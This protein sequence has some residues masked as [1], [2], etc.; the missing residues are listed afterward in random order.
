MAKSKKLVTSLAALAVTAAA[1]SPAITAD[2]A[3]VNP[4]VLK[5]Q[6]FRGGEIVLPSTYGS[7]RIVWD[8]STINWNQINK[9]QTVYGV[10]G[11]QKRPIQMQVNLLNYPIFAEKA[12]PQ[13]IKL[14]EK[15]VL[16]E[17]LDIKFVDKFYPNKINW[18]EAPVADKEGTFFV[19]GSYTKDGRTVVT[20][21]LY[22]VEADAEAAV[23]ISD[24]Q[25]EVK[26][27]KLSVTAKV[28]NLQDGETVEL[29]ILPGKDADEAIE[30]EADVKDGLVTVSADELPV[31]E[32]SFYLRSGDVETKSFD[33]AVL[34]TFS[35]V[36]S[37][38]KEDT[39][40]VTAAVANL[41]KD[42]EVE[43]VIFPG[44]DE[45]EELA[46]DAEVKDGLLTVEAKDI[47]N[48]EH[49]FILRSGDEESKAFD[50]E[51][52]MPTVEEVKA[53]NAKTLSVNL[54]QELTSLD[55]L[56]FSVKRGV[57]SVVLTSK[58]SEDKKSV[59]LSSS[60][61]LVAGEYEVTVT[62]GKF[63]AGTNSAKAIV[64]SQKIG[65]IE[66]TGDVLAKT[67]TGTATVGFKAYDQYGTDITG[68]A[69]SLI[70]NIN[71]AANVAV[72][73]LN[74][75]NGVLTIDLAGASD[76]AA[77]QTILITAVDSVTGTSKAST[78][79]VGA[80]SSVKTLQ[81]GEVVLP[82]DTTRIYTG[83][84]SAATIPVMAKDQY[85]N[86][87]DK[88][89]KLSG[90][91]VLSSDA[92]VIPTFADVDGKPVVNLNTTSLTI[93]KS[94][95][96]TLVVNATGETVTKTVEIVK[97]AQAD[98]VTLGALEA[99]VVADGDVANKFVLPITVVNQFGETM[100]AKQI[101]SAGLVI[102]GT[103]SFAGSALAIDT[104]STS[105]NYGKIVNTSAIGAAGVGTIVVTSPT[106]KTASAN[107]EV[108]AARKV[109]EVVAPK[110]VKTNL[111]SGATTA[112][113]YQFKDQY[114]DLVTASDNADLTWK[115]SVKD[116]TG[117][118]GVITANRT[119]GSD[120]SA[121]NPVTVSATDGKAGTAKVTVELLNASNEVVSQYE[122]T[123]TVVANNAEGLTYSVNDVPTLFASD[124]SDTPINGSSAYAAALSFTA[125]DANG[126]EYA[127]PASQILSVDSVKGYF[128]DATLGNVVIDAQDNKIVIGAV[129]ADDIDF[130][131]ATTVTD[132]IKV[133]INT[134]SGV[135][136]ISK[137][138]TISKVVPK[139]VE[140]SILDNAPTIA[141]P[142]ELPTGT[143]DVT[144]LTFDN[145][146]AAI[147]GTEMVN[148]PDAS[149]VFVVTK[150]QYGVYTSV[151]KDFILNSVNLLTFGDG[152]DKFSTTN[153]GVFTLT[154][155][156]A[157][158]Q[159]SAG[160]A[161]TLS[162]VE[163]GLTD[164]L[165]VKINAEVPP[166][167]TTAAA[168]SIAA[169]GSDD[170]EF[171]EVLSAS[172]KTAVE[173]AI[174][175]A[176]SGVTADKLTFSWAA[177]TLTVGNTGAVAATFTADVTVAKVTDLFGNEAASPVEVIT[178]P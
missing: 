21:A 11:S 145:R 80:V 57:T 86:D 118:A 140:M 62:G 59:E 61:N 48:G 1:V 67:G 175:A 106:G 18:E 102:T 173:N 30:I 28:E 113:A 88:A 99:N 12:E 166:T 10:V 40:S 20:S 125:K 16:P 71:W 156:D 112:V 39:L 129:D 76:F 122:N 154:D 131:T 46:F 137:D 110:S 151:A 162:V 66:F 96:I 25:S 14:G 150:D 161:I 7:S 116:L 58:L 111:V 43:L 64:G 75:S 124:A 60:T 47:P 126:N 155:A 147:A 132:T 105:K 176:V 95:T 9:F 142:Y 136:V 44:K 160:K 169:A 37:E 170:V 82:K 153:L 17:R 79:T 130:G 119:T 174:K 4:V 6:S 31:G 115:V 114:G 146:A 49:S 109:V 103:G 78:F 73:S 148:T 144:A 69:S 108:K 135:K 68:S 165:T 29:V 77:N 138:V 117:D 8:R 51:V 56:S 83:A 50:F 158:T 42:A 33:F 27:D 22:T 23:E 177:G 2:A 89:A 81:L 107:Y 167:V 72:D 70:N 120:E 152:A 45:S 36:Q 164:T 91:T 97:P 85:G 168:A 84:A 163:G 133:T 35:K 101:A 52:K 65:E 159:F 134:A 41:E 157:N 104:D 55:G 74:D 19:K 13:V 90:V 32:H 127:I 24:V 141:N 100:T 171:S 98:V 53:I 87:L 92:S 26:K 139:A 121:L 172:S 5:A 128:A 38:V 143:K 94:V 149:K 123:F 63:E 3:K 15:P 34:P 93:A 54:N 178:V